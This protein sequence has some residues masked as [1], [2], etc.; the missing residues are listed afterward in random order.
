[1]AAFWLY[2]PSTAMRNHRYLLSAKRS[3]IALIVVVRVV[4]VL[5]PGL[6]V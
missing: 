3:L 1:M 2:T 6:H 5:G 4:G